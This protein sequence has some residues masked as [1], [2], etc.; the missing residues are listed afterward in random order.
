M[1][2]DR[3]GF[4]PLPQITLVAQL[5]RRPYLLQWERTL[6]WRERLSDVTTTDDA[7]DFAFALLGA[8]FQ[9][10]D[11]IAASRPDLKG[12]VVAL[13]RD[14]ADLALA[15]DVANGAK[16]MTLTHYSVDGSTTIAY[17]YAGSG[18]SHLVVLR[19]GG[20]NLE[21]LQLADRGIAQVRTFMQMHG[22]L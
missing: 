22:L 17:E 13:Y 10:R 3:P 9:L 18:R 2:P 4:Q 7:F 8:L 6:R 15:R 5:H 21:C 12:D 14:S 11:W 20:R 19:P 1:E 16:H